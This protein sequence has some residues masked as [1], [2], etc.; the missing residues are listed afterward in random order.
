MIVSRKHR[1]VFWHNPKGGGTS[2]R[3][4]AAQFHDL[5][6]QLWGPDPARTGGLKVDMAHL[7]MDE[8]AGHFPELWQEIRDFRMLC[9]YRDPQRRFLSSI[10]EYSKNFTRADL[11]FASPESGRRIVFDMVDRLGALGT[12]EA[13]MDDYTLTHFR[14][15]HIYWRADADPSVRAE[16]FPTSEI[17]RL[18]AR[19]SAIT[20]TWI[21][22]RHER[23]AVSY[24]VPGPLRF[25]MRARG[26]RRQVGRL[27]ITRTLVRLVKRRYA[28]QGGRQ[29]ALDADDAA[30]L[31]AFVRRFY[32]EDY[33]D[34]PAEPA[35]S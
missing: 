6:F 12:A 29:L 9:L 22:P 24:E 28:V 4:A 2:I 23:A 3:A 25:I 31:D 20:G 10:S 1:F 21:A 27:P 11:R 35:I 26:L 30:R 15:Q 13:V 5:D 16:A 33:A 17:D 18:F 14:P 8:F 19:L 34:W 7:G 32:A